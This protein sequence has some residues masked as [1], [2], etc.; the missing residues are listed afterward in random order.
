[1]KNINLN[2]TNK[3]LYYTKNIIYIS[4][5]KY[6]IGIFIMYKYILI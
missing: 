6:Y 2:L 5:I 1:M 4:Y 3:K